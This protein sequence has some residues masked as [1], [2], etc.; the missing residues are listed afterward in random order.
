MGML[1][2]IGN[3]ETAPADPG[4]KNQDEW[5][6]RASPHINGMLYVQWRVFLG[7]RARPGVARMVRH[8]FDFAALTHAIYLVLREPQ[9]FP[10]LRPNRPLE[11]NVID[12]IH[13]SLIF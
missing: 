9:P 7:G 2:D 1:A 6:L 10:F 5:P 4:V 12:T 8:L 13:V 3:L 11:G